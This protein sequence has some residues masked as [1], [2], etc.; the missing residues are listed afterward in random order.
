MLLSSV[1]RSLAVRSSRLRRLSSGSALVLALAGCN[2]PPVVV[3]DACTTCG[4]DAAHD[5]DA[6]PTDAATVT[7]AGTD[8][9]VIAD[10]NA[11]AFMFVDGGL[12]NDPHFGMR[13]AC[14][15]A[16]GADSDD[17]VGTPAQLTAARS[18]I[19]HVIVIVQEN[20]SFDHMFGVNTHGWDGFP[21]GF[22][23]PDPAGPAVAP[24]HAPNFCL[25]P[26]PTHQWNDI[27]AEW[28]NGAMDGFVAQNGMVSM[29]YYTEADHP[30]Y[31][32]LL[33]T[34]A[35]SDRYFCDVLSGTWAN[36]DYLYAGTSNGVRN[37]GETGAPTVTIFDR[38]EH[39]TPA[40]AW[41]D[42]VQ[43]N[44]NTE[45]LEG[46]LHGTFDPPN[47]AT[48]FCARAGVHPYADLAPLLAAGTAVPSLVFVDLEPTDEHP[49]YG[50]TRA[51]E[52][53]V[54][55]L[56]VQIF[57]SPIWAHTA[58]FF[59]YDEGGG[60]V[61]HVP[62]PSA[63][64]A[65]PSQSAFDRLGMRV[66]VAVASP[67]SRA[68]YNSRLTHSHASILRFIET[69]F[70]VTAISGRDANADAMLDM[71]DFSTPHFATVTGVV[72]AATPAA[73]CP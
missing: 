39:A 16:S 55:N 37:T 43:A 21:S 70:D 47:P 13:Q 69:V 9:A 44:P 6:N 58:V 17:T 41:G 59:T 12:A 3:T 26:R 1:P 7:D 57:A 10:A 18:A 53:A 34:F 2:P 64:L 63:C 71:F 25:T 5:I 35:T 38:L 54:H 20:R 68:G 62:P 14:T 56:M 45:C 60:F 42:Y 61:D 40:I 67:Y 72:N 11:D 28:H 4:V 30:F 8:A 27:H 31:T 32:W 23:N 66:P 51:G 33:S 52:V 29:A 24:F 49:D 36:R 50:D 19:Q 73:T 22:T 15:Y 65:A 46:S 48:G